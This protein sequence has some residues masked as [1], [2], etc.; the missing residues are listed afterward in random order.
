MD[1]IKS[2]VYTSSYKIKKKLEYLNTLDVVSFDI[3]TRSMYTKAE[4][5]LVKD[6]VKT[7][8]NPKLKAN[9]KMIANSS[10]L[11]FPTITKTTH[12][13]FGISTTESMVFIVDDKQEQLVFDWLVNTDTKILIWNASFDLKTVY[14]RTGKF[15]KDFEDLMIRY[16]CLINDCNNYISRSGLKVVM[17]NYYPY[18]WTVD[19]DYEVSDMKNK[20]FLTYCHYDGVSVMKAYELINEMVEE[21]N[22]D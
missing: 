15:P 18:S 20:N 6:L 11:S 17:A 19:T 8:E 7:E 21:S 13:I 16:K 12:I 5:N 22:D 2:K 10:G 4:R 1:E 14:V 9:Y 3:E